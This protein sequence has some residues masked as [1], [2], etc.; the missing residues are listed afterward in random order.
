[1]KIKY[2]LTVF[3][4]LSLALAACGT[5][6]TPK[7]EFIVD[8][9]SPK[10]EIGSFE[11]Q[12]NRL[13]SIGGMRKI[14]VAVFYYPQDDA[15]CLKYTADLMTYYQ[16]WNAEG[17][18]AY[19]SAL[20]QYN[21]DYAARNLVS[22]K[23]STFRQYNTV[24]GYL[25][26]QLHQYSLKAMANMDVELGYSF[27]NRFPYFTVNQRE[28]EYISAIGSDDNRTSPTIPMFFTRAQA[29]DLAVLFDPELLQAF[30]ANRSSRPA[31]DDS[32][33]ES[34]IQTDDY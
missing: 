29:E 20:A 33:K 2:L 21:E 11:T 8:I 23:L 30:A 24:Q 13:L 19:I 10:V 5:V 4:A 31:A 14:N 12:I 26:W 17:R 6:R 15:V 28:A 22:N 1:M 9:N 3:L 32:F 27:R 34:D 25:V 18:A 16:F 7:K